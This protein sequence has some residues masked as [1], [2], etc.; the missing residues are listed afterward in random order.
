MQINWKEVCKC[1][2]YITLKKAMTTDIT[3]KH[4]SK[5]ESLKQFQWVIARAKHYAYHLRKP[6]QEV[7]NEWESKRDYWWLNYY[8][9]SRQPKLN[10]S[11]L[12]KPMSIRTYHK[13]DHWLKKDPVK[14]KKRNLDAIVFLQKQK[15]KRK[16]NKERWSTEQKERQQRL[17]K[18]VS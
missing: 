1:P 13:R 10:K 16:G 14:R 4:R 5:A 9:E 12:V 18:S 8:Q 2:G 11:E 3:R 6:I 15:T 17:K 7:L